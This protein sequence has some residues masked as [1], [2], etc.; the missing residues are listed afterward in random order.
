MKSKS[1]RKQDGTKEAFKVLG[2]FEIC[3]KKGKEWAGRVF[4]EMLI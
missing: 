3:E 2:S 1:E 4:R